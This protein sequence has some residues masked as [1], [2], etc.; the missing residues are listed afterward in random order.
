[1]RRLPFVS[2]VVAECRGTFRRDA[3]VARVA[4]PTPLVGVEVG[5]RAA[6][7]FVPEVQ[8]RSVLR[9][10]LLG[11]DPNVGSRPLHVVVAGTAALVA[12]D[13]RADGLTREK[14]DLA[15][16]VVHAIAKLV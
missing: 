6:L 11:T 8:R 10:A 14:H 9:L 7:R 15:D 3:Q 12:I 13:E 5:R 2:E 16:E 4:R 1:M